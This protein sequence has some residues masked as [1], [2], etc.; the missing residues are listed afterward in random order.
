MNLSVIVS[1]LRNWY[2]CEFNGHVWDDSVPAKCSRCGFER[3][4]PGHAPDP[5]KGHGFAPTLDASGTPYD[6]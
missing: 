5:R 6:D 1:K 4:I 2:R 3:G